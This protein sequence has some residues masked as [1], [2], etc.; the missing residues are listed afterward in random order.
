MTA[1]VDEF[2]FFRPGVEVESRLHFAAEILP[3]ILALVAGGMVAG[4]L[5]GMFGIGGGAILVPIFFHV[6][7]LL[8]IAE[9]VRMQLALGTSLAIIVPTS[10]R[11]FMAHRQ[12]GSVD[13]ALLRGWIVAV[14]LGTLIATVIAAKASSVELRLIFAVIAL[15]LAFRMIFNR[16][17]WKLGDDLPGNPLKFMVGTGIGVLSGL[18]GIGGGVLN[19]T[20]MTLYGRSIHQAVA[21]SSGVGVLISLPGLAGYVWGG[22]GVPGLPPFS[23]GYIN[24]LAVLLLIPI[25]LYMAPIG[26]RLAHAMSKRQ[27][28]AGFGIFLIVISLQF[29]LTILI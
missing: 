26:A 29:F 8:G 6:F 14:P 17:S 28:E 27:L 24:W 19:N 21:T 3:F 9:D 23:T 1:V 12:R 4:L 18:M 15:A 16:A 10:I 7:G 20:F 25:T 22:W 5:A 11:S 13:T 2:S